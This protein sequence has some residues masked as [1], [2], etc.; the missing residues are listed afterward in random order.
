MNLE[1]DD[2]SFETLFQDGILDKLQKTIAKATGLALVTV[3]YRG[4]PV[5]EMT[6]FCNFCQSIR[7]DKKSLSTCTTSDA[8]GC[9]QAAINQHRHIY[10]CHR[11]L[12]EMAVPIMVEGHY[13][14]GF[15]G[16]QMRCDDAPAS[17][18]RLEK[19]NDAALTPLTEKQRQDFEKVPKISFEK[20]DALSEMISLLVDNFCRSRVD[21]Y[22]SAKQYDLLKEENEAL[23]KKLE[24]AKSQPA[25]RSGG[26][27][28]LPTPLYNT[29]FLITSLIAAANLAIIEHAEKT[30]AY[31]TQLT[32]L[33]QKM[34]NQR[35]AFWPVF[36]EKKYLEKY[37]QMEGLHLGETFHYTLT[38]SE[39]T[40]GAQIPAFATMTLV[41]QMMNLGIASG[42]TSTTIKVNF[43][44]DDNWIYTQIMQKGFNPLPEMAQEI[45]DRRR[46]LIETTR[47]I[48]AFKDRL[49]ALYGSD[50]LRHQADSQYTDH[51]LFKLP[52][53]A[54]HD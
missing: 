28:N 8:Y 16:G 37:L 7:A 38:L 33:L 26:S 30:N 41:M 32:D 45:P 42:E 35:D 2:F 23:K 49:V 39:A 50:V 17:T 48:T 11:G 53:R 18:I 29:Q 40:A 1:R 47:E 51:L 31:T 15:I 34:L 14:G 12:L 20:Y 5:S 36:E 13:I 46:D 52:K 54:A 27:Q 10:F 4:E 25:S 22:F 3:N 24:A 21:K 6:H 9:I 19:L 43:D 44:A